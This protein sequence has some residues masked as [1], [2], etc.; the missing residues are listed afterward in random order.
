VAEVLV[1]DG[2]QVAYGAPLVRLVN[3]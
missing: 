1:H 2:Q 3:A